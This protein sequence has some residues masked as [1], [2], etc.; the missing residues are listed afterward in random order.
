MPSPSQSL[1]QNSELALSSGIQS[2][3]GRGQPLSQVVMVLLC[4]STCSFSRREQGIGVGRADLEGP[5]GE[6]SETGSKRKTT[7]ATRF[8]APATEAAVKEKEWTAA[9]NDKC[10]GKAIMLG[11]H[12]VPSCKMSTTAWLS[13]RKSTCFDDQAPT[14]LTAAVLAVVAKTTSTMGRTTVTG[15][16]FKADLW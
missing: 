6:T 15:I 14:V 1:R 16:P 10:R 3:C 12:E 2:L 7:S 8:N 9:S 13:E 5:N 11:F 4:Q